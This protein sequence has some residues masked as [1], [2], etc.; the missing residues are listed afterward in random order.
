M[1]FVPVISL[2]KKKHGLGGSLMVLIFQVT[3]NVFAGTPI[4]NRFSWL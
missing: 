2:P 1:P 4:R 3:E